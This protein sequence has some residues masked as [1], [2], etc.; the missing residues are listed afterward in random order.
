MLTRFFKRHGFRYLSCNASPVVLV[1]LAPHAQS[2]DEEA[3]V[4]EK[5]RQAGVIVGCGRRYHMSQ[6][7]WARVC[8]AVEKHDLEDAIERMERVFRA[9]NLD[10]QPDSARLTKLPRT[11][12]AMSRLPIN[13]FTWIFKNLR[14]GIG[15]MTKNQI[16]NRRFVRTLAR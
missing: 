9:T 2:W 6:K 1:E 3:A 5:L 15:S 4:V 10:L 12:Y 13:V 11:L 14:R 16:A 8:F 7:G